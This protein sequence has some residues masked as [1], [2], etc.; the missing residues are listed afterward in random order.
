VTKKEIKNRNNS[1]KIQGHQLLAGDHNLRWVVT[2]WRHNVQ[3]SYYTV[4]DTR[5]S[6][7]T[8]NTWIAFTRLSHT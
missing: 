4:I 5:H 6:I 2:N 8:Q 7:I 3:V 1:G